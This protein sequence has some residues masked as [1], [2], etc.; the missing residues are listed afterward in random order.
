[1][2]KPPESELKVPHAGGVDMGC[3]ERRHLKQNNNND[4]KGSDRVLVSAILGE[5]FHQKHRLHI[6][7][8]GQL[9]DLQNCSRTVE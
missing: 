1:M 5:E 4:E 2:L 7:W 3:F 8:R 6:A 9:A